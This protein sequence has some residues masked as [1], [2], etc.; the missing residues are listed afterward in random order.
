[1][2]KLMDQ[3][4]APHNT[5]L[6]SIEAFKERDPQLR[7]LAAQKYVYTPE[8]LQQLPTEQAGIYTLG[9]GRQI[10]NRL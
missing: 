7:R 4:F 5:H 1:M 2:I 8:L 10:L 9:G 6:D 3:R